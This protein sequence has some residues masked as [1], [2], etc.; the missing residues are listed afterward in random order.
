MGRSG[1]LDQLQDAGVP[2]DVAVGVGVGLGVG[3]TAVTVTI[4]VMPIEQCAKQK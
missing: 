4:P 1:P 3:V 2:V